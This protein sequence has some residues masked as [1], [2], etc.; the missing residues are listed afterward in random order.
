VV[1][2]VLVRLDADL[3]RMKEKGVDPD[4]LM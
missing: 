1:L 3:F 4:T 2:V